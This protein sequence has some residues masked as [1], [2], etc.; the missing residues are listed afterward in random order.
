MSHTTNAVI[1]E[2]NAERLAVVC[3]NSWAGRQEYPCIV[4][5]ETAKRYR[6]QVAAPTKLPAVLLKPGESYLVPKHSIRFT[7]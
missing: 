2:L 6:I 7:D 5:G 1:D 3:V 4:I